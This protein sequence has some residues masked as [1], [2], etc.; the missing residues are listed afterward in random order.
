MNVFVVVSAYNEE[1]RVVDVIRKILKIERGLKV[2]V[3]DD[4][5]IDGSLDRLQ[6]NFDKNKRVEIL[7]HVVNLGKGAAM[8]T[9]VMA[10]WRLGAEAVIFMDADGQH[11][12]KYLNKFIVELENEPV[13]FGYRLLK[14]NA[15]WVRRMGNKF[16]DWFVGFLFNIR[17]KDTICGFW[18]F[19]KNIYQKI[20]WR[21]QGY[22]VE[23]EVATKVAKQAVQFSE[24]KID[25]IYIDKYKGVTIFD[26]FKILLKVPFWF[27][28][29]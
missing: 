16:A 21:S 17:R 5:S 18:G 11:N 1:V 7:S 15:P 14:K 3:V 13:V 29:T 26:A 2:I 19:R 23:M 10:A 25:T 24:V 28:E 12:P 8:K 9:G 20:K 22:E 27:F 4:G 6:N